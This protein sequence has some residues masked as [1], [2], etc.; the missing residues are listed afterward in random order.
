MCGFAPNARFLI[1][2][3]VLQ[4][5]GGTLLTPASL[6]ILQASFGS[7]D[8]C[9]AIGA[10]SGL[11]GVAVAAG[12]LIGGYLISA[13]SWRWMFFINVPIAVAVVVLAS[14]TCPSPS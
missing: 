4:G 14:G 11:S 10:W 3:R 13:G 12:P 1:L 5:V 2:T 9:R 8:R 7:A 6:A